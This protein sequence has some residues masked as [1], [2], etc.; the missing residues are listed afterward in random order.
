MKKA[1][2]FLPK[3]ALQ[4]SLLLALFFYSLGASTVQPVYAGSLDATSCGTLL[5]NAQAKFVATLSANG[6]VPASTEAK[7]AA[8][9]YIRVS[10]LCY[11][12]LAA[13][14]SL[15]VS[16]T[17][18]S[19][20]IDNDGILLGD[21]SSAEFVLTGGKWGSSTMG[22][23]GG[24]VTYSFMG[25]ELD[26]SAEPNSSGFGKSVAI[27]SLPNFK[28][29]FI[30]VI[31]NAFAAWQAVS[32]IQFVQVDDSNTAFGAAGAVGDIRIGAHAFDGPSGTLAHAYFPSSNGGS[33]R[34]VT[35]PWRSGITRRSS[36][37]SA[38]RRP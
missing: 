35:A 21:Q 15:S 9:E 10:K 36:G 25:S 32:N 31:Q 24:T 22:T 11:D 33:G 37:A 18:T 6:A 4:F 2:I 17:D 27:T 14:N 5:A 30:T 13:Q 12:E 29:C 26:L 7:A 16:P 8:D 1:I 19:T 38:A 23:S 28:V 3:T 20:F 34:P